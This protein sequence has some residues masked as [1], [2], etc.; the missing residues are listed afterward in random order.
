MFKKIIVTPAGRHRYIQILYQYLKIFYDKKQ[1][2]QWDIWINTKNSSDI[3]YLK[4]LESKHTWIKTKTIPK[5]SSET[6]TSWDIYNFFRFACDPNC[7]YLRFDD[8]I[9][10]INDDAINLI[11]DYR[12]RNPE[13]FLIYAN[14]INNAIISHLHYRN[15]LFDYHLFPDYSCTSKIAWSDP[16]FAE[17][18]HRAFLIDVFA[19]NVNRWKTTFNVWKLS[20]FER[21]SINCICWLGSVFNEFKGIVGNDE[22]HWLSVDKPKSLNKPNI[23]LGEAI[24][25]HYSFYVQR[26][27][28]DKTDI[29]VKYAELSKQIFNLKLA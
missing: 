6:F 5:L 15:C 24:V 11:F 3:E 28:L 27:H 13:P 14:I 16:K 23:I 1:F 8:D 19:G 17:A 2:D 4:K 26:E 21:V 29:L 12:L 25:A 9:V 20:L 10:F 7:V 18:I 22:E